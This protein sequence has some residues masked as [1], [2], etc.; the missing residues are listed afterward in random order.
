MALLGP[1]LLAAPAYLL[2]TWG[3]SRM[4]GLAS[5]RAFRIACYAM[6]AAAA[7]ISMPVWDGVLR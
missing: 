6:I 4:F 5:E 1:W 2:G 3:G 7:V